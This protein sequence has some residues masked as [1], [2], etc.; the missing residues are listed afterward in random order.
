MTPG[1]ATFSWVHRTA[2]GSPLVPEVKISIRRS[3]A[4]VSAK[5]TGVPAYP[6]SS[7]SHAAEVTSSTG[8]PIGANPSP[9]EAGSE[10]VRI[11]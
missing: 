7:S 2:L 9:N 6:A 1:P 5:V 8:I 10:S 11:S 3:S 4:A